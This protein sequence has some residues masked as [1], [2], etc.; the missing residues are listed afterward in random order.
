MQN[1]RVWTVRLRTV[2]LMIDQNLL[3]ELPST[4]FFPGNA[5]LLPLASLD[6][7]YVSVHDLFQCATAWK[8]DTEK[9]SSSGVHGE[10]EWQHTKSSRKRNLSQTYKKHSSQ[11]V[12][13]AQSQSA[14]GGHGLPI[15][16]FF[17]TCMGSALRDRSVF[18]TSLS[19]KRR[20]D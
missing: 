15:S 14:Q 17:L 2:Q 1:E 9:V 10:R 3:R 13:E 16:E 20:L 7:P 12:H 8:S 6:I 19:F 5:K 18:E 11:W 4:F